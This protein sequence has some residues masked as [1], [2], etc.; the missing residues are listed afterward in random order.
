MPTYMSIPVHVYINLQ[1][2]HAIIQNQSYSN[3]CSQLVTYNHHINLW[4]PDRSHDFHTMLRNAIAGF[5][6]NKMHTVI[7]SHLHRMPNVDGPLHRHDASD[8]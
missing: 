5:S 7:T 3:E 6:M 2:N 1:S 4:S 8:T